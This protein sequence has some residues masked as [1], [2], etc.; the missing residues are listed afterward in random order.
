MGE[1][2]PGDDAPIDQLPAVVRALEIAGLVQGGD[3][4]R[5]FVRPAGG[6]GE[7]VGDVRPHDAVRARGERPVPDEVQR[8][9]G[10]R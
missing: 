9:D 7:R 2:A 8:P 3:E 4:R 6:L 1:D 10:G 5:R